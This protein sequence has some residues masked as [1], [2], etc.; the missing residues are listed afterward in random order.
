MPILAKFQPQ[1]LTTN[2]SRNKTKIL[3]QRSRLAPKKSSTVSARCSCDRTS[4]YPKHQKFI[5]KKTHSYFVDGYHAGTTGHGVNL[6]LTK[7]F[8]WP[9]TLTNGVL[10]LDEKQPPHHSSPLFPE[11]RGLAYVQNPKYRV[12][13]ETVLA[14]HGGLWGEQKSLQGGNITLTNRI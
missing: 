9:M 8:T 13:T 2:I 14:C 3:F 1:I 7:K 12:S 10:R 6:P 5:L 11:K 4:A